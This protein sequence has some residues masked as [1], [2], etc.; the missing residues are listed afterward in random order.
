MKKGVPED[1]INTLLESISTATG[2][3][4]VQVLFLNDIVKK[5]KLNYRST[6]LYRSALSLI[7]SENLGSN[8]VLKRVLKGMCERKHCVGCQ[9]FSKFLILFHK[10][11]NAMYG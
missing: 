11:Y 2:G 10:Y 9:T 3:N 8:P 5:G 6:N 4:F 7:P 1:A